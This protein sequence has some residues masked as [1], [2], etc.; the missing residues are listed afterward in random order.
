MVV[1]KPRGAKTSGPLPFA[2]GKDNPGV[3]SHD[4]C[5]TPTCCQIAPAGGL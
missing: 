4:G 5:T 3:A 1:Q 2:K